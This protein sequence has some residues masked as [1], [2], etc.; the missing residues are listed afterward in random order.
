MLCASANPITLEIPTPTVIL[1]H[2]PQIPVARSTVILVRCPNE[3][4]IKHNLIFVMNKEK[5]KYSSG[6][7]FKTFKWDYG[8]FIIELELDPNTLN[9]NETHNWITA[10]IRELYVTTME[11]QQ[12]ANVLPSTLV[13]HMSA[14]DL[15]LAKGMLVGLMLSVPGIFT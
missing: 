14:A 12:C 1:I 9:K 11:E 10:L 4:D 7:I 5:T 3:K 13:T 6:W 8:L 2:A 15:T